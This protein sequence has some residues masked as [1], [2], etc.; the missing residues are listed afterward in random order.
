[1]GEVFSKTI[2]VNVFTLCRGNLF[3]KEGAVTIT[4]RFYCH[5]SILCLYC[6]Y[7]D[8]QNYGQHY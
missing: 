7:D 3:A 1:M 4:R 6:R 2:A 5:L 8:C